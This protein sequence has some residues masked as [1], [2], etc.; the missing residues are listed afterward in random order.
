MGAYLSRRSIQ[1]IPTMLGIVTLVFLMLR[2]LPGDQ[3]CSSRKR[4][5]GGIGEL[6]TEPGARPAAAGPIRNIPGK[7]RAG[8]LR[9]VAP[10]WDPS[11]RDRRSSA[12]SRWSSGAGPPP[13]LP[14]RGAPGSDGRLH[15]VAR[16]GALDHGVMSAALIVDTIPGFWLALILML[17]FTCSLGCSPRRAR[18]TPRTQERFSCGSCCQWRCSPSARSPPSRASP[19]RPC[20]VLHEDYIRTARSLG[21]SEWSVLFGHALKNAALPIVTIAVWSFGRLLGGTVLTENIFAL[22]GMGTV[23]INAIFSRDYP[24]VQ[25]AILL[26]TLMFVAVNIVTD[27]LYTRVDPR[28]QL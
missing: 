15:G 25:G 17:V 24:V 10:Q 23:L 8:E 7:D 12:S 9:A 3:Q 18:W 2:M 14:N 13:E 6:A 28:V 20:S 16:H 26:Y 22:P 5:P 4:E 11:A 19:A 1:T 21:T 27:M